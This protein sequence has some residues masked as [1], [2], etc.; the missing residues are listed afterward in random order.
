M[1]SIKDIISLAVAILLIAGVSMGIEC[2]NK[3]D[4]WVQTSKKAPNK[5]VMY[6]ILVVA[7]LGALLP[8]VTIFQSR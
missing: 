6:L 3:N 7:I 8:L 2:Y 1:V 5:G 4:D